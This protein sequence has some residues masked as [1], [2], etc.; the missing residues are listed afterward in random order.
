[1]TR[2]EL[3]AISRQ[4]RRE[5][6]ALLRSRMYPGAYYLV[7]Y[8]VECALKACIA[9]QTNRYDFPNKR[10]AAESWTHDL[11]KLVQ[12]AGIGPDLDRDTK[13]S[14]ALQLNW[15]ITKDWS[16]SVRYDLTITAAEAR[17]LYSACTRRRNG[18]L[19][20]IR[21]KW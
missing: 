21:N 6:A 10:L 17:D 14:P 1:M 12:L 11:E 16:E 3:Q 15:A 13:A 4:R 20:W 8:S 18:I 7:G 9:K 19:P 5:A 2:A